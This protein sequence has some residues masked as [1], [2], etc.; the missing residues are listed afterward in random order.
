ME[1]KENKMSRI[2]EEYLNNI[3]YETSLEIFFWEANTVQKKVTKGVIKESIYQPTIDLGS[4][5]SIILK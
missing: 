5:R 2:K 1:Q 3:P 4:K